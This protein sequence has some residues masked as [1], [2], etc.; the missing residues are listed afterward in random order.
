MKPS[1]STVN[2]QF[3][4]GITEQKRE[5]KMREK[6]TRKETLAVELTFTQN[7]IP[8]MSVTENK[9]T[10]NRGHKGASAGPQADS[11]GRPVRYHSTPEFQGQRL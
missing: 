3:S 11:A 5:K 2:T 4:L 10:R 8:K 7:I 6:K 9:L 1:I